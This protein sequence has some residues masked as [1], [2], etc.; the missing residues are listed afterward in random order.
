MTAERAYI[1]DILKSVKLSC[2]KLAQQVHS[3]QLDQFIVRVMHTDDVKKEVEAFYFISG[4]EDFA[5][6]LLWLLERMRVDGGVPSPSVTAFGVEE[7]L[8]VLPEST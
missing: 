4:Y 7:L 5:L 8:A 6:R 2:V 1:V 3:A